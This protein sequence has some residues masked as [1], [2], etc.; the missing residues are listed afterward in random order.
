MFQRYRLRE[1]VLV[2]KPRALGQR[3]GRNRRLKSPALISIMRAKKECVSY[4]L[5][6]GE[7]FTRI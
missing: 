7:P 3:C 1:C 4:F 2:L 5:L 6:P